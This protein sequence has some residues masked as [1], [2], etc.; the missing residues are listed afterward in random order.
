LDKAYQAENFKDLLGA[1]LGDDE[2]YAYTQGR[3]YHPEFK[4]LCRQVK[5]SLPKV[6]RNEA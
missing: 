4:A 5:E 1:A 2:I 6:T 3:G